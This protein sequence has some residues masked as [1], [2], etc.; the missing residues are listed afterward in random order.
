MALSFS[1]IE[2]TMSPLWDYG[3]FDMTRFSVE[4]PPAERQD[5]RYA[6]R[7]FLQDPVSQRSFCDPGPWGESIQRHGPFPREK[8]VADWFRPIPPHELMDRVRVAL[9]DPEFTEPPSLEQRLPVETWVETVKARGDTAF[10]LE[11]PDRPDAR[12]DWALV[13]TVYHE[14]VSFSP[15]REELTVGVIGY[16]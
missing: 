5:C 14:F 3:W 7:E 11:A 2:T 8:L 9:D 13:W 16:D 15:E 1:V 12:V 10:A 4:G 6:L